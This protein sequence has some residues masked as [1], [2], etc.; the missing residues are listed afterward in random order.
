MSTILHPIRSEG[1]TADS[2]KEKVVRTC[3]A[4]VADENKTTA[5][6]RSP[7]VCACAYNSDLFRRFCGES[8][9]SG[10]I[11]L[12]ALAFFSC[13]SV[14]IVN[15]LDLHLHIH[16]GIEYTGKFIHYYPANG[17]RY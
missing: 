2:T 8:Q 17:Q 10:T 1:L 4:E 5:S 7:S 11:M 6:H 14:L 9:R 3:S 13:R 16:I 12:E 15:I